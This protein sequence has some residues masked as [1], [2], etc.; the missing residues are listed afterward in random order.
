M[1]FG[2]KTAWAVAPAAGQR[3]TVECVARRRDEIV[4]RKA[5]VRADV[6]QAGVEAMIL[7]TKLVKGA[8]A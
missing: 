5:E 8:S 3:W 2:G 7:G 4:K 1:V 6:A